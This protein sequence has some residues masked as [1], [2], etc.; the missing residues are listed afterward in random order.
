MPLLYP[1]SVRKKSISFSMY[2]DLSNP[3]TAELRWNSVVEPIVP[4]VK[5]YDHWVASWSSFTNL[6]FAEGVQHKIGNY[7][8]SREKSRFNHTT[9]FSEK[10]DHY[11]N[12]SHYSITK[13]VFNSNDHWNKQKINQA[14]N[15]LAAKAEA[16][17]NLNQLG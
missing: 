15:S 2:E 14:T 12:T 6:E 10:K 11:L 1:L 4:I 5:E 9:P 3:L 17:W 13:N 7:I 16:Y 8:L